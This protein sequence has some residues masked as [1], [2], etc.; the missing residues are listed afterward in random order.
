MAVSTAKVCGYGVN[1]EA[2]D[3][4]L[5]TPRNGSLIGPGPCMPQINPKDEGFPTPHALVD[6]LQVIYA[7]K[8]NA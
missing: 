7:E 6:L 5:R 1:E 4:R 2:G 8:E 3:R